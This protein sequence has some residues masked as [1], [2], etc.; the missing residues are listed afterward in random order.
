MKTFLKL[1]A[2]ANVTLKQ[3]SQPT[4]RTIKAI[5]LSNSLNCMFADNVLNIDWLNASQI[6]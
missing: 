1:S 5:E 2:M 3:L 6:Q 4:T